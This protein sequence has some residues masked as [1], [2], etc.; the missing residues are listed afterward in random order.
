MEL[1]ITEVQTSKVTFIDLIH[2]TLFVVITFALHFNSMTR[3][4]VIFLIPFLIIWGR[5][6]KT[7]NKMITLFV[8]FIIGGYASLTLKEFLDTR[9]NQWF[10]NNDYYIIMSR[11][12]LLIYITPFLFFWWISKKVPRYLKIGSFINTIYTPFIWKGIKDP[13]W[14]ALS[15]ACVINLVFFSF[16]ID[17]PSNS[18]DILKLLYISILFAIINASLEEILWRGLLLSYFVDAIGERKGLLLTSFGFGLYHLSMGFSIWIS[19]CF[20]LAGLFFGGL[21]IRSKGIFPAFILH[22]LINI[23]MVMSGIIF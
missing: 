8:L 12:T 1:K 15:V 2:L 17:I 13:I 4:V 6:L 22:F 19:L 14:R 20:V 18:L 23:L 11:F 10:F 21:A 9:T 5:K 7:S 16:F 3:S